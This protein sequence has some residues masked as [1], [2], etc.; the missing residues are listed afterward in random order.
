MELEGR[1]VFDGTI[2]ILR[3]VSL[4]SEKCCIILIKYTLILFVVKVYWKHEN[5]LYITRVKVLNKI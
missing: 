1:D 2:Q 5:T 3:P 4:Y